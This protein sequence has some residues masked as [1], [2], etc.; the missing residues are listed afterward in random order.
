MT[1]IA[2]TG[3]QYSGKT[4]FL[5]SLLWQLEELDG[6]RFHLPDGIAI[7]GFHP[8]NDQDRDKAFPL[9]QYRNQLA[10]EYK[11]PKKTKDFY[12]YQLQFHSNVRWMPRR[13]RQQEVDFLDMPGERV[14]DAAMVIY[15]D[16]GAWSDHILN[17]FAQDHLGWE[18][19]EEYRAAAESPGAGARE[20][21]LAYRRALA[22]LILGYKPFVSPSVF[23]LDRNGDLARDHDESRLVEVRRSGLDEE[24]EFAPLPVELRTK[25]PELTDEM[26]RHYREYREEVVVPLFRELMSAE[27]LVV[28]IDIPTL[29]V[30]GDQ[31]FWDD[32]QLTVDLLRAMCHE[33]TSAR[34]LRELGLKRSGFLKRVAFAASKSDLVLEDDLRDGRLLALLRSMTARA[35]QQVRPSIDVKWFTCSACVSTRSG[36]RPNTIIGQTKPG[37]YSSERHEMEFEV[38]RLPEEWPHSWKLDD[39]QFRHFWPRVPENFMIPPSHRNMDNI[40]SFAAFG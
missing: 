21:V 36:S 16:F 27:G 1:K 13:H 37:P 32:R 2:V 31:R 20:I 4:M 18:V 8:R 24:R 39:Y 22:R 9:S 10:R 30:A 11:W 3:T 35:V 34:I 15:E 33:T 40:F 14:A 19:A 5:T 23:L 7:R 25:H 17:H 29:L 12:R 28:L 38:S 6:S 26:Q